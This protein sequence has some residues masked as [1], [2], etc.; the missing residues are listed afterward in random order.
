MVGGFW[1]KTVHRFVP[2]LPILNVKPNPEFGWKDCVR[3]P[4][5]GRLGM[6]KERREDKRVSGILMPV[7][8]LPGAYGIGDFGEGARAFMDWLCQAGVRQWSLLPL[9]PTSYGNSPYQSPSA[10]A[11]NMNY[12]SPEVLRQDGLLSQKEL[13]EAAVPAGNAQV[14]YGVLFTERPKLLRKAYARFV[15]SGG[16]QKEPFQRFCQE[17]RGWLDDYGAFMMIKE[18]M[19]YL[20]WQQWPGEL[21]WRKEPGYSA[22]LKEHGEKIGFWKFVQFV[23]F[24]Q[25]GRLRSYA[26]QR[27]IE[28]IG[29]LPFYLAHDSADVWSHRE[30]FAVD[31]KS[32][33]VK[34]WAGVPADAFTDYDRSWGNPVYQWD[35]HEAD[36]YQWFRQRIRMSG[37]MYDGLRIDHVIAVMRFFGIRD[38]EK[39][40][41]WY[42]GPDVRQCRLSDAINEEAKRSGLFVIAEDLGEVPAGL[43]E[44]MRELGWA[45]MRVLQFAFT[46]KY[47]ARSN[48]LPFFHEKD[49]VVYTSTHDHPTLKCYLENKT[50]AQLHYMQ[51]WTG[52]STKQELRWALI[53]EAYKSAARQVIIPLQDILGLGEEARMVLH[54]DY[55]RSWKW[56]L[57]DIRLLNEA[58]ADKLKRISVLTGRYPAEHKEFLEYLMPRIHIGGKETFHGKT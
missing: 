30:L 2:E 13:E 25:W 29:D 36:G 8:A 10:F 19:A 40:G 49:M 3:E 43:R 17:N 31:G 4:L 15:K 24:E 56:R 55:E 38:G 52:K 57:T 14:D 37:K 41:K 42:K 20:P 39:K 21:A 27:G 12:I 6:D 23:F 47:D 18:E 7:S 28:I 1:Y 9:N 50:D 11:G 54:E 44:R 5:A 22:Y 16:D 35:L 48:H 53:E 26:R 58:L 46:E 45:G 33:Q 34:M 51:W 32:G